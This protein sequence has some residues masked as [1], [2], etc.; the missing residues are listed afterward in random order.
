MRCACT[1]LNIDVMQNSPP[2]FQIKL[3]GIIGLG[4][5]V[6][7]FVGLFFIAKGIFTILS[8]AAPVLLIAAI[9]I[10][11]RTLT[12]FLKYLWTL[13]RRQ[14]L[15][16]ILA[17]ILSVLGFPIVCGFLFGK[18]ILDRKIRSYQTTMRREQE[19]ELID[20]EVIHEEKKEAPLNLNTTPAEKQPRDPYED[21]FDDS[22]SGNK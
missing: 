15:M 20:Y 14:P 16:G 18:A 19:G 8:W 21:L 2:N 12:G 9:I 10:H 13:L 3:N 1:C 4:I 7:F 6:L 17:V 11:Y 5:V 22:H